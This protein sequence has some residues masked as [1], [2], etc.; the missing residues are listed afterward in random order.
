MIFFVTKTVEFGDKIRKCKLFNFLF[1]RDKEISSHRR[2]KLCIKLYESF[3]SNI[4]FDNE[5]D[6]LQRHHAT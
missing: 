5:I 1:D 4:S 6:N 2:N 3:R